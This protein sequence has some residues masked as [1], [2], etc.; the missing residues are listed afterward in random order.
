MSFW[1]AVDHDHHVITIAFFG[2]VDGEDILEAIGR[3]VELSRAHLTYRHM[4]D[5]VEIHMLDVDYKSLLAIVAF[6]KREMQPLLRDC[7]G[8]AVS[9]RRQ[10]DYVLLKTIHVMVGA[11][12]P[13]VILR[14]RE[15]AKRWLE[16]NPPLEPG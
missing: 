12:E 2:E 13:V 14:D 6:I 7:P 5:G 4:W 9:L 11:P 8:A 10:V 3:M 1:H 16:V 15:S